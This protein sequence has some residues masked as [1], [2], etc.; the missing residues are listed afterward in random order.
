MTH[1][2]N[3]HPLQKGDS[4]PP[5]GKLHVSM[6]KYCKNLEVSLTTCS[7]GK[8]IVLGSSLGFMLS[9]HTSFW[10]ACQSRGVVPSHRP[11]LKSNNK[12]VGYHQN[13]H[14]TIVPAGISCLVDQY[15]GTHGLQTGEIA[16]KFPSP[17]TNL[18]SSTPCMVVIRKPI[19]SSV[20]PWFLSVCNLN[21]GCPWL[22]ALTI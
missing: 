5:G 13:S 20:P 12:A 17:T 16:D 19:S 10:P 8:I 15:C 3:H 4:L 7:H 18:A 9:P 21:V 14:A 22:S 6:G 11:N 1:L 2:I